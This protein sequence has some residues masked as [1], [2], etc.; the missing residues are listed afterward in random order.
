MKARTECEVSRTMSE[1]MSSNV[2]TP[3]GCL[4]ALG[5]LNVLG[6]LIY[7]VV[8][9]QPHADSDATLSQCW[10]VV[11]AMRAYIG[12]FLFALVLNTCGLVK[13]HVSKFAVVIA[14]LGLLAIALL[15]WAVCVL[16]S[17]LAAAGCA[18]RAYE[19]LSGA[20]CFHVVEMCCLAPLEVGSEHVHQAT[21]RA[22]ESSE[23]GSRDGYLALPA[24]G[25]SIDESEV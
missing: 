4:T 13:A 16:A 19:A 6:V 11:W 2:R 23:E 9:E 15:I 18:P 24:D 1:A 21:A 12:Y 7:V 22:R 25:E 5:E 8:T 3:L 20:V 14:V 17:G 10:Q